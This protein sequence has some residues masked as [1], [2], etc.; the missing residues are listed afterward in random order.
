[1]VAQEYTST[2]ISPVDALWTII[3]GQSESV[4]A[5]L[6]KR[7]NEQHRHQEVSRAD[8]ESLVQRLKAIENDPEGFFKMAGILG[9]CNTSI[10]QLREEALLEKYG[11]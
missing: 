6:V 8:S 11:I 5:A 7:L 4:R 10:E 1:M 2:G 9:P 3:Q